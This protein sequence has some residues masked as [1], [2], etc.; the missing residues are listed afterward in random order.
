MLCEHRT[1]TSTVLLRRLQ[2]KRNEH[3]KYQLGPEGSIGK[4]IN[5]NVLNK[6]EWIG[7]IFS[8][9][10]QLKD[11]L[12]KSQNM[13]IDDFYVKTNNQFGKTQKLWIG[14][15]SLM[16]FYSPFQTLQNVFTG[17]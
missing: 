6:T 17:K 15:L 7:I 1:N 3:Y 12:L 2:S 8:V 10:S 9:K 16:A 4:A 5:F 11:S 13:D 14:L